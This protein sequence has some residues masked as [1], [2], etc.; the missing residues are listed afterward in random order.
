MSWGDQLKAAGKKQL[1]EGNEKIV[2]AVAIEW[3]SRVIIGTPVDTGRA[4][5]NWFLTYTTPSVRINE[6]TASESDKV[7]AITK[8]ITAKFRD[9]Y[10]LT[11]N[12]P[13]IQ[14]LED[15]YSKQQPNGWVNVSRLQVEA[16]IPTI[17]AK[18]N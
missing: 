9:R 16:Q 12:L 11:N 4:R 13:Y 14:K 17:A 8:G 1:V 7:N 3:F 10:I 5:S 18:T 6:G 15:G 2:Q